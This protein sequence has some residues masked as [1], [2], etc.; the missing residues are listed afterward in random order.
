ML[1]TRDAFRN[2]VFKRDKNK[3]VTCEG[4]G[5][6]AHHIIERRL[7]PDG[8]YYIDNGATL[9]SICHLLAES[10]EISCE[11]IRAAAKITQIILPPHLYRDERYDKW[12]NI[13][14]PNG[15]RIPGELFEDE[16]VRKVIKGE[17]TKYIKYPRTYHLPN[18]PGATKDDRTLLTYDNFINNE[19]II[20]EKMDGEN[21]T[22]YK[23]YI[24]A[25][26]VSSTSDSSRSWVY[27]LQAKIGWQLPDNFRLCG[28]NLYA[29]HSIKYDSL[30]SYF[31]L[32][33]VWNGQQC[34]S[35]KD[36][37]EWAEL[38]E[39][40]TIPVLYSGQFNL[41]VLSDIISK[42]DIGKQ[43]GIVIRNLRSFHYKDFRNNIAKYVRE[44]HVQTS[45]HWK[46]EQLE[47]NSIVTH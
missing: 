7:F 34:L 4:V 17:F 18:S 13:Y 36:T 27:N 23:D 30:P 16:S 25:R 44:G 1:L 14:L 28:E 43:E 5:V 45:H 22:I 46:Y 29:K 38:L 2:A 40:P 32:F 31:M 12:G 33:S 47:K 8:G 11:Q 41:H 26:S 3:C 42:L 9:C 19:V 15:Q 6:D 20:S 39:V 35:W 37:V 10:T 24:H 21:T